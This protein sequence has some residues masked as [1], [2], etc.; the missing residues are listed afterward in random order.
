MDNRLYLHRY[1]EEQESPFEKSR[2]I[3]EEAKQA[4]EQAQPGQEAPP[5]KTETP[6]EES[7]ADEILNQVYN[8]KTDAKKI[9]ILEDAGIKVGEGWE[10]WEELEAEVERVT[11]KQ[12][13]SESITP[14]ATVGASGTS[15]PVIDENAKVLQELDDLMAGKFGQIGS[16]AN[17]RRMR[18]LQDKLNKIDPARLV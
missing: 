13:K 5:Q 9:Q 6:P 2:R 3:V 4:A 15:A 14:S 17:V 7:S 8:A 12:A 11:T 18:E 10:T 16:P 1:E